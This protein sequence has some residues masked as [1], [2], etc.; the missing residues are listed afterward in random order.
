MIL[1]NNVKSFRK[2]ILYIVYGDDQI[3]YDGAIFSFLTFKYWLTQEN[4]E[5][6]VLTEK[7]EKF[8]A[9]PFTVMKMSD[10]QKK[11]WSL[12]G[13]YHFRIK[14]RG[15]AYVMDKLKIGQFEKILFL[16]T[17]TY[18]KKNPLELFDLIQSD[19]ALMYLNEGLIY[20]RKRFR[21]YVDN[22]EGRRIIIKEGKYELS[23]K[24]A[25]WGSLMIGIMGNM[26]QSIDLADE[27]LLEFFDLIPVHTIEEFSLSETLIQNYKLTEGKNLVSLY[28][29]SRKKEYA[30]NILS[31]FFK[32][33]CS[34][35]LKEQISL[36]QNV[37]IKRSMFI[38]LKQR[39]LRLFNN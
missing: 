8:F 10:N 36:A 26:R 20:E 18:F 12:N 15:M 27:L 21:A 31:N 11:E 29:T 22:L 14:N 24:S 19:Q 17:D 28:S 37:R 25:L 5:F 4:I 34:H 38:V 16:D 33:N 1:V 2:I 6:V 32:K 13:R 39:F 35:S 30:R 3:Y 9:Y 23:K 7:P